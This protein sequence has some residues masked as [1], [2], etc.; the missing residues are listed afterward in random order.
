LIKGIFLVKNAVLIKTGLILKKL[1][2]V[3]N[4]LTV[5]PDLRAGGTA[6][7]IPAGK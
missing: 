4:L 6:L 7:L 5:Y 3:A 1:A 2:A